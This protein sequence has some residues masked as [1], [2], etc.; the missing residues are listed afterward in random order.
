M[1]LTRGSRVPNLSRLDEPEGGSLNGLRFLPDAVV[2][3]Y[4]GPIRRGYEKL[5][6]EY[7]FLRD[8]PPEAAAYFVRLRG[9][10]ERVRPS[11]HLVELH[12]ERLQH[13]AV[14][15]A[16]LKGQLSSDRTREIVTH[17]IGVLLGVLYPLSSG[18]ITGAEAYARFHRKR[19]SASIQ[20]LSELPKLGPVISS[21]HLR[22][23]GRECPPIPAALAW[24]DASAG[25]Y[26]GPTRVVK[27]HGDAHLDNMLAPVTG[28]IGVT[29]IDPRGVALLP[30][31]YDFAKLLKAAR[32]GYD[33]VHYGLY[34]LDAT[35]DGTSTAIN[36]ALDHTFDAQYA[37]TLQVL[38]SHTDAFADAEHVTPD[39]FRRA[40]S[41][42]EFAHVVSFSFYHANH[43]HGRDERRVIAYLATAAL[44]AARLMSPG[45]DALPA[46][47]EPLPL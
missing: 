14:A 28:P 9:Y 37:A 39:A 23:N 22:V 5:Y 35:T 25:R 43:P 34:E 18:L 7:K 45:H 44:L 38:L 1:P 26:F 12:L 8:L 41:A 6:E 36:L 2:K 40:A 30:P 3:S 32:T 16:L 31:H 27:A 42:A 11:P 47:D 15:K 33:L 29:F 20:A 4:A 46:L 21:T 17:A 24:L 13:P 10:E 19:L